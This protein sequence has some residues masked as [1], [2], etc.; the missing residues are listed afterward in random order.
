MNDVSCK[1]GKNKI[2]FKIVLDQTRTRTIEKQ[3]ESNIE[4]IEYEMD[5]DSPK[6][7]W[8][9]DGKKVIILSIEE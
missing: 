7:C 4:A 1:L 9:E 3:L 5:D 2:E 6:I 8:G